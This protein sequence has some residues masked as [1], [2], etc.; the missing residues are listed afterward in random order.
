MV[1]GGYLKGAGMFSTGQAAAW[2]SQ[3][4]RDLLCRVCVVTALASALFTNDTCCVVSPSRPGAR[5]ERNLPAKPPP[6][7]RHQ[8]NIGSSATPSV[9]RRLVIASKKIPSCSSSRHPA[10]ML[11]GWPSTRSAALHYWKDLEGADD[12]GR[13][14]RPSRGG[15]LGLVLS[16]RI[17]HRDATATAAAQ[18]GRLRRATA[19]TTTARS[20]GV[21][22]SSRASRTSS[23]LHALATARL[24]CRGRHYHR[25]ALVVVDF[26]DAE[27]CR[28]GTRLLTYACRQRSATGLCMYVWYVVS[29][30]LLVFFSGMFVTVSG[31]NKT[32]L[33]GAI[34]NFMAP[35]AKV[36]HVSGVTVLSS[37]SCSSPTSL[38]VPTVLLMG[39]EVALLRRPSLRRGDPVVAAPGVGEHGGGQPV[40]PGVGGE[41]IVCEQALRAPRNAHDLSFWSHVVFGVP[42]TLVVTAIGIPLIGKIAF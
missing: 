42:S 16:L 23:P 34:W 26:R 7:A 9:T 35:Y 5:R 33:P 12:A 2:R 20:T 24:T 39:D 29:Y 30:S 31:F 1:V 22:C 10:A 18:G 28:Q 15:G 36:N 19:A 27:P 3:G 21:S 13:R 8:R 4:G 37:S 14:W 32:G 6:G 25:I 41:P 17:A 40:A 38:H 11:P